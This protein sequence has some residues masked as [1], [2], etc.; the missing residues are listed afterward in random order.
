[1][2]DDVDLKEKGKVSLNIQFSFLSRILSSPIH[3]PCVSHQVCSE[4]GLRHDKD[5]NI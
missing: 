5:N 3:L 1:M 2:N 4:K